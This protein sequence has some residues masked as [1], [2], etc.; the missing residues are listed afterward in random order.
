MKW[1][2]IGGGAILAGLC[3]NAPVFG[4]EPAGMVKT[5]KG[6][7]G[8]ERAGQ[9]IPAPVGT[10]VLVADRIKTGADGAV[11]VTLRDNTLLSAGP[12]S[13]FA[14]DKFAFNSTTYE[15]VVSVGVKKGTL[16]VST[17]KIAKEKP[18]SVDFR[19]PTSVIGVHGTEFVI[20]TEAGDED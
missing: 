19:T 4:E 17:G 5:S 10:P 13:A 20:E 14:I 16:A 6:E 3:L 9:R 15:G 1:Y 8:I 2:R 18:E 12:N 7:V 11:G